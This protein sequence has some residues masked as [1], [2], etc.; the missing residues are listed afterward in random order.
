M[1]FSAIT[2][3]TML[4]ALFG[5]VRLRFFDPV[6]A[7]QCEG[8]RPRPT[9]LRFLDP[10]FLLLF[11]GSEAKKLVRAALLSRRFGKSALPGVFC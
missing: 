3:S 7:S 11:F 10:F 4:Y 1:A 6:G 9:T 8:G 5:A 2:T